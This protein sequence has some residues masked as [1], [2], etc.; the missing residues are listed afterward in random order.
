MRK[1]MEAS[2]LLEELDVLIE[3]GIYESRDT[4]LKDA[5]RSLLRSKPELRVQLAI[6][7][8]TRGR[9]SFSRAAEIAGV[10]I[11]SL[12][13]LMREVGVTRIIPPVGEAV[14]HEVEHLMRLRQSE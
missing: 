13:E 7:L 2:T 4:L 12:K 10:D 3:R 5:M 6:G 11:E 14:H 1:V 8:Y 9:V